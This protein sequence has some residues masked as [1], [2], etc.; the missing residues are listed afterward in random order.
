MKIYEIGTGYT[1]IPA[2]MGAATEIVVE[3]LTKAFQKLGEAV[4]IVDIAAECRAPSNLPIREVKV[5]GCFSGTD[6]Q[7]G[8]M[9]KLKRVVYSVA[10]AGELTK[11]LKQETE[12]VVLHFHNQYNLFFF[13]KLVPASLRKKARIAYTNHSGIWRLEWEKIESIIQKRYFQEAECMRKADVVFVLNEETKKNAMEHLGVSQ[14]RL[15]CIYNGVNTDTYCPLSRDEKQQAKEKWGLQDRKVILQVGS[16][17]ENKGQLRALQC[18]LPL[19]RDDP[20]VTYVYAGGVVEEEYQKQIEAFAAKQGVTNQVRYLGMC[21][22]GKALNEIYN[23]AMAT[24]IMSRYEGFALVAV[25]SL[26]AGVPVLVEEHGPVQLGG[27]S[28]RLR[29]DNLA[30]EVSNQIFINGAT[31]EQLCRESRVTAVKNY[32]WEKIARDVLNQFSH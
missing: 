16:V 27:G 6:V 23:V 12:P 29:K 10:L 5:P 18:L 8:I 24:L 30:T 2:T 28:V 21:L 15:V 4:Q 1:P 19:L 26:A 9:H 11:I 25:E 14:E 31:Y 3:E 13:L 7:L 32:S 20:D 22:P 17:C